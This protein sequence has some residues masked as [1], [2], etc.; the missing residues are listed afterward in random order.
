MAM[1]VLALVAE[2][3]RLV[4][5]AALCAPNILLAA[6]MAYGLAGSN[7]AEWILQAMLTTGMTFLGAWAGPW[8]NRR[9][10]TNS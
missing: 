5:G 9:D 3:H 1:A 7:A 8:L 6:T 2:E 4:A 10:P